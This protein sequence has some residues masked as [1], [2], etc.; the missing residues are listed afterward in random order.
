MF[1][2]DA[3]WHGK[4]R[5]GGRWQENQPYCQLSSSN[6]DTGTTSP[7]SLHCFSYSILVLNSRRRSAPSFLPLAR[8]RAASS[9]GTRLLVR[10]SATDLST[11]TG[12]RT[13]PRLSRHSMGWDYKTKQLRWTLNSLQSTNPSKWNLFMTS[14]FAGL[15]RPP[16]QWSHQ[17]S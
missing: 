16:Q 4:P 9:S 3:E 10:A 6:N 1:A 14:T 12:R 13:P 11:T 17:G 2:D 8:L 15:L 5:S 7:W